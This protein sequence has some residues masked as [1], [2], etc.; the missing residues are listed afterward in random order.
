MGESERLVLDEFLSRLYQCGEASV[1]ELKDKGG[2]IKLKGRIKQKKN[3]EQTLCPEVQSVPCSTT[4]ARTSD[5]LAKSAA[6]SLH[7]TPKCLV[8]L[9]AE[10]LDSVD[11][12]AVQAETKGAKVPSDGIVNISGKKAV[13]VITFTGSRKRKKP[14]VEEDKVEETVEQ[15]N[16]KQ[17][18]FNLARARLEVHRFGITGY[19]KERQRLFEQERAV[20]L[21]ARPPKREY[22]NYKSYQEMMKNKAAV[23]P[24]RMNSKSTLPRRKKEE[25]RNKRSEIIPTGQVGRFKNGT[26]ILSDNDI[27]RIKTRT[28]PKHV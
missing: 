6:S 23:K 8:K 28:K 22:V 21:G 18:V 11:D 13:E 20:M 27:K 1:S 15:N 9:R 19:K 7:R 4:Q 5:S 14:I 10:L 12:C 25:R 3:E 26:L 17:K 16:T 24:M 2:K